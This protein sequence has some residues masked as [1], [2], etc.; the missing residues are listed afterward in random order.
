MTKIID[1][2]AAG[3][4][5]SSREHYV[6]V[7]EDRSKEPVRRFGCFTR[8]LH[9]LARFLRKCRIE[10][11][12]MESTGVYW[13]HLY[14]VL[15]DHG[16]EVFLVNARHVK[17]VP[18]RKSDVSDAQWLQ[19]LHSCGLLKS[20]FQ[21]D[22]LTRALRNY[23]RQRKSLVKQMSTQTQRMQKALEQMNIKLN[24]V[25]SDIQ[26][27]T[28][29]GIISAILEGERD[30][31]VLARFRD[32]RIKAS[33]AK[34]IMS[35]EGTWR[36]EHLFELGLAWEHYL[37]LQGQLHKCDAASK[38][39]IGR[40]D[41]GAV[42]EK[43]IKP[44]RKQRRQP[45]F[46][47]ER[48]LYRALGT[49]VTKIYGLSGTTALTVFSETGPDLKGKFPTQQQ[50][51]SWLNVVPDNRI[52]GG[53]LISSRVRKRKNRAGQAFR[54]AAN[55]LWNAKNVLGDYLRS[56][57]ARS[58]AGS[59]V[60]ATAK[61]IA[62]IYYVMVTEKIDF[63]PELLKERNDR[64]LRVKL[65]KLEE[66]LLRTKSLLAENQMLTNSVR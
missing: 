28:G 30:P 51:L 5:I 38:E 22:N 14:T 27:K 8:D 23:V 58:G 31:S 7:P 26:G 9:E 13:Y 20:C 6:A 29:T 40:M 32:H 52:T 46:N 57:K 1:P 61:K 66:A 16:F 49:E 2:N 33:K 4:D 63:D 37:F 42:P 18:G 65:K 10:T 44:G 15:L 39:A 55:A 47:V 34:L 54:E 62:S 36:E 56:K 35:L 53:K 3:I 48:A 50:F 12:A 25:I 21:P 60:V 59:A 64:Y 24:N 19:E 11:V 43:E 45:R 41:D 17:N